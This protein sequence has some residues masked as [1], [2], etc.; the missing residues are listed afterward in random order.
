MCWSVSEY[1]LHRFLF[2]M[3]KWMP[4]F[5][6]FRYLAF[7]IH[8]IHHALP[9]DGYEWKKQLCLLFLNP[10]FEVDSFIHNC[11]F[12]CL[13]WSISLPSRCCSNLVLG[14][15]SSDPIL[16]PWKC[17]ISFPRWIFDWICLL[18]SDSL[19]STPCWPKDRSSQNAQKR[20]QQ[21]SLHKRH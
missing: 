11:L 17:W 19:L 7:A 15:I 2:H 10:I 18:R 14:S 13:K 1:S 5:A 3:E 8:G 9:M 6:F 12:F 20:A 4:D 16:C 21:A